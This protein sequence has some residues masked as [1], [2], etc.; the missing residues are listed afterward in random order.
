LI[1]LNLIFTQQLH[2]C[3]EKEA[4]VFDLQLSHGICSYM[5]LHGR[6]THITR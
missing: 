5:L 4:Y 3:Y 6:R 1:V 2:V